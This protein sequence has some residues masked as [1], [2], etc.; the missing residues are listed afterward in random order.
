MR[1]GRLASVLVVGVV[2]VASTAPVAARPEPG[3]APALTRPSPLD[4]VDWRYGPDDEPAP[5]LIPA[6][7]DRDDYERTS[8]RDPRPELSRS[9]Q[10]LC[11]QKGTAVDL[12][13]GVNQGRDD[14]LIAVLDSG[15]R[16]RDP[17]AMSDLALK[18]HINLAEADPPCAARNGDCNGDGIFD[19]GD[20]GPLG[21]AITDRNGNGLP[22]PED[23][24]LDPAYNNGADDDRNGYVD[25]ISGWDLLYGDNNPLDTP[26]YG[27]GTGEATDSTAAANGSRDVG[28]CPRCRFLPVR[29]GTSFI[30]DGGRFAGG[31]I[32][33]LDSGA[34][35]I[36][37]ALGTI[38]NPHQAQ[39]A[40]DAAYRRGVPVVASM[41]DEASK[42]PNLASSL[43]HTLAVNSV[44]TLEESPL[45]G[46]TVGYLAL[47][48]CT[49]F[50]GHTF[51]TISSSS[52]SSEATGHAAGMV[53]LV[54]SAARDAHLKPHPR[55]PAKRG[56]NVL[57]AEEVSQVVRATADDIDFATPNA[58]DPPN[59]VGTPTGELLDTVRYPTTPG[60]D[61]TFGYGRVNAY[62]MVKEVRDGRVPPEADI[63]SPRWFDM[64][65]AQ[66]RLRVEGR[67]AA[68][69]AE[70]YDYRVEW[71]VG[72]Q[73]PPYPAVDE[74]HVVSEERGEKRPR[75]GRLGTIRLEQ[76]AA[77][78]PDGGQGV[79][80]DPATGLPD[81][82]RFSVR[83]R[84]VVTAHGGPGDG[85]QGVA[86]KQ[87][88]VHDDPDLASGYPRRVAGAG[89][90]SPVFADLD[91]KSGD[92]LIVATDDGTVHAYDPR[93]HDIAGWPVRTPEAAWWPHGSPTAQADRI[94]PVR[95]QIGGGGPAVVDLDGDDR[96]EVAVSDLDGN[97]WV[98]DAAAGHVAAS[99]PWRSAAW[100]DRRHG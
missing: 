89:T 66:G 91:G 51:V 48:G 7:F 6:E 72:L 41:A 45:G 82:E 78:L 14:V 84:V 55:L 70:S 62:E 47:N 76:V 65:S 87:V 2:V 57:S 19:I 85:L 83:V 97:V 22:D 80:V 16:W 54:Q 36:Q 26:D 38:S 58:V 95:G 18:A 12:A 42:H 92:E 8:L 27:H 9:P 30:A 99:S 67:V 13:W 37:E 73:P 53:G 44:T 81:E 50:G 46:A 90:A 15:I 21:G 77:A 59:N 69:R 61:A 4:C 29:V 52:C 25:D 68:V 23:L 60:W 10:N 86:Q 96:A 56:A 20:F 75:S 94:A 71:A 74:W 31:V 79:P 3:G 5:G 39:D 93:G 40:I 64:L 24:I 28:G 49:N 88:F 32:F 1:T 98:W 63:T 33:S 11:G 35:V 17:G 100:C 43:E 34:D